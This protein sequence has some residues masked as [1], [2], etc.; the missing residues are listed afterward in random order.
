MDQLYGYIGTTYLTFSVM[1][2]TGEEGLCYGERVEMER[3]L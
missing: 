1:K 3:K 2:E